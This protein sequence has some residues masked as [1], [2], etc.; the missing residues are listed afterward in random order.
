M[1]LS[2]SS[3][4]NALRSRRSTPAQ[5]AAVVLVASAAVVVVASY[6]PRGV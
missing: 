5:N 4:P 6:A 2:T 3:K 1:N